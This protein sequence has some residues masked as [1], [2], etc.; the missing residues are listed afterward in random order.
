MKGIKKLIISLLALV[1]VLGASVTAF[2]AGNGKIEI[3]NARKGQEYNAYRV[4]DFTAADEKMEEGVYT[5]SAKF[6]GLEN[7]TYKYKDN[8]EDK[9]VKMTSFFTIGDKGILN[10]EGLKTESDAALFGKAVLA[11][12]KAND[13]AAD[14]TKAT[15]AGTGDDNDAEVVVTLD[16]LEYGY[17]VVDSS[18][19]T[20]VAVNTTH[21][22]APIKEKND[23][24][25]LDKSI[26][27]KSNAD[28][29]YEDTTG[30]N[31]QIGDIISFE[32]VVDLKKGGKNYKIVDE[33][34]KGL[35][36]SEIKEVKDSKGNVYPYEVVITY[37]DDEKKDASGFEM[38]FAEPA[39]DATVTVSYTAVVNANA[40]ISDASNV[41][42][43][44][45]EYGNT[46]TPTVETITKTYPLVLK[47]VV[48]NTDTVL[49]GA[50]FEVYRQVDGV[51]VRFTKV[52]D[53]EY[54]VNPNADDETAVTEIVTV[55]TTPITINGL[56][57]ATYVLVE[58][59]APT[60]YNRISDTATI[61]SGENK[62]ELQHA[63][64]VVISESSTVSAPT[65][66]TVANFSGSLLP[67]TG[68]VGVYVFYILGRIL[69]AAGVAYFVLRR[70]KNAD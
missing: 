12:A 61:K 16:G 35:T 33:M 5:L 11:Y 36:F 54:T 50:K 31:A 57:A 53:T 40:E 62:E 44:Y 27:G 14:A 17:Y 24:P 48:G 56:D 7:Y 70:M 20:A 64:A 26:T 60:G 6:A 69:I 28:K 22:V 52:S 42:K 32:I 4:F 25:S 19:G 55:A 45:L 43:A 18:L 49:A 10:T 68:G 13:I 63:R 47:K 37:R 58:T 38:S 2:A 15:E 67:S 29:T 41:N 51:Q 3:G 34:T 59:E 21:P 65:I 23:V 8:G 66:E 46:V 9:E 30:N 39:E 1:M